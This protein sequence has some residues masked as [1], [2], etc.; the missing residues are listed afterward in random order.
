MILFPD[1]MYPALSFKCMISSPGMNA[2]ELP[3]MELTKLSIRN[4]FDHQTVLCIK[5]SAICSIGYACSNHIIFRRNFG[6]KTLQRLSLDNQY[7]AFT[8]VMFISDLSKAISSS[9]LNKILFWWSRDCTLPCNWCFLWQNS[10]HKSHTISV[11]FFHDFPFSLKE[12]RNFE[13]CIDWIF[14]WPSVYRGTYSSSSSWLA[15]GNS[16]EEEPSSIL[17]IFCHL[18]WSDNNAATYFRWCGDL[19]Q[20]KWW[21]IKKTLFS[22]LMKSSCFLIGRQRVRFW[23]TWKPTFLAWIWRYE[24]LV[25]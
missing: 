19:M 6:C 5:T 24:K 7:K 20:W 3:Y 23:T 18:A 1:K 11:F 22:S 12:K 15:A 4:S 21:E 9:L 10:P 25:F 13:S 16:G 2:N 17:E 14:Q 8:F